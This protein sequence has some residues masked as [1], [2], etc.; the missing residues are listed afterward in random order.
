MRNA[1]AFQNIRPVLCTKINRRKNII[2]IQ[3]YKKAPLGYIFKL[4][5]SSKKIAK[6]ELKIKMPAFSLSRRNQTPP[7]QKRC[8]TLKITPA[9]TADHSAIITLP[10]CMCAIARC[11]RGL[12]CDSGMFYSKDDGSRCALSQI[13]STQTAAFAFLPN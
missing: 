3:K 2:F 13:R 10:L 11:V 12:N 6:G 5:I 9:I 7:V 8:A 1:T 4:R